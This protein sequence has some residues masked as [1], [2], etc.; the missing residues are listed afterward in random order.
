MAAPTPDTFELLHRPQHR[1]NWFYENH[2][3]NRLDHV[4]NVI[5]GAVPETLYRKVSGPSHSSPANMRASPRTWDLD[6]VFNRYSLLW[7]F[8]GLEGCRCNGCC[9]GCRWYRWRCRRGCRQC[10]SCMLCLFLLPLMCFVAIVCC[11]TV[12]VVLFVV[13]DVMVLSVHCVGVG[14]ANALSLLLSLLGTVVVHMHSNDMM[15]KGG[16]TRSSAWAT[17]VIAAPAE[18]VPAT[19]RVR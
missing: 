2:V 7:I 5:N 1:L 6:C 3:Q 12:I 13:A 15:S 17:D 18:S 19:H 9:W 4:Q 8:R 14:D 16:R 10:H 11:R